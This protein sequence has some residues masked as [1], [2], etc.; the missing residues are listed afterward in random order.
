MCWLILLF[1]WRLESPAAPE[2]E[3]DRLQQPACKQEGQVS[4]ADL[5]TGCLSQLDQTV[6]VHIT[7]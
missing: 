7:M 2:T 3:D 4:T 1:V 5:D 6:A